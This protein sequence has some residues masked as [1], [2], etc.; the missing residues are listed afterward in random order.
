MGATSNGVTAH[1]RYGQRQGDW[2]FQRLLTACDFFG[3]YWEVNGEASDIITAEQAVAQ[4]GQVWPLEVGDTIHLPNDEINTVE[5]I[6]PQLVV[7]DGSS[8]ER[9]SYTVR[10]LF[11]DGGSSFFRSVQGVGTIWYEFNHEVI[12]QT[13]LMTFEHAAQGHILG[14]CIGAAPTEACL[15]VARKAGAWLSGE[16]LD[17]I[18]DNVRLVWHAD[19]VEPATPGEGAFPARVRDLSRTSTVSCGVDIAAFTY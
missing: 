13:E 1:Y 4:C 8:Q 11:P 5:Q 2:A 9:L 14:R 18:V 6:V 16:A 12:V 17:S 19:R 3:V 7:V 15:C 10:R